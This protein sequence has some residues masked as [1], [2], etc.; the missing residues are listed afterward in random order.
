MSFFHDGVQSVTQT[1]WIHMLLYAFFNSLCF[2]GTKG[3]GDNAVGVFFTSSS[4]SML[5]SGKKV[6]IYLHFNPVD[7]VSPAKFIS[8]SAFYL[9]IS[10]CGGSSKKK[11]KSNL[12]VK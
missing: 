1:T 7:N 3:V 4:P 2:F 9:N 6:E 8:F 5:S 12:I 10:I 11:K